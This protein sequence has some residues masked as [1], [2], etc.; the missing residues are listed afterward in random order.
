[1]STNEHQIGDIFT[2][3]LLAIHFMSKLEIINIYSLILRW[4]LESNIVR[5]C[6][7]YV[8][9]YFV[10]FSIILDSIFIMVYN[11]FFCTNIYTWI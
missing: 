1:M 8:T 7:Y 5:Y 9:N 2:N 4:I 11:F 10:C 3:V 6:R